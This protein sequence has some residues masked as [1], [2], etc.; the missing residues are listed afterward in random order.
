VRNAARSILVGTF[1]AAAVTAS[2]V[3]PAYRVT[4]LELSWRFVE[5][6]DADGEEARRV[7]TC[8]G[9]STSQLEVDI[10][11]T[12]DEER[13]HVFLY[14]CATGY[15]TAEEFQ[16]TASDAFISLNPGNYDMALRAVDSTG[17]QVLMAEANVAVEERVATVYRWD[18]EIAPVDWTLDLSGTNACT[19]LALRLLYAD[20]ETSL[21]APADAAGTQTGTDAGSENDVL[22]RQMLTSDGGLNL[23][24]ESAACA[25]VGGTHVF[26]GVDTGAYVLE[27]EVDGQSCSKPVTIW[28]PKPFLALDL[29]DLSC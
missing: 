16:V 10:A 19:N 24:G 26:T 1:F 4:G 9:A 23:G 22:Y 18:L 6:N 27:I 14:D 13:Q 12:D 3:F 8:A 5:T 2:C 20:P 25:D 11:D 21:A 29:A 15:Q 7:R 17:V 28:S